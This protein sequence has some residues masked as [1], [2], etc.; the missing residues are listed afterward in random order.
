MLTTELRLPAAVE[1]PTAD[2]R[3]LRLEH[4]DNSFPAYTFQLSVHRPPDTGWGPLD[5]VEHRAW[6]ADSDGIVWTAASRFTAAWLVEQLALAAFEN[7]RAP[8]TRDEQPALHALFDHAPLLEGVRYFSDDRLY[9]SLVIGGR[10][11]Q[12]IFKYTTLS[13]DVA[14]QTDA[15]DGLRLHARLREGCLHCFPSPDARERVPLPALVFELD[16]PSSL[17]T[18]NTAVEGPSPGEWNDSPLVLPVRWERTADRA[19][20]Q[21]GVRVV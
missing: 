14:V 2:G 3:A 7:V 18:R 10:W 4:V 13:F 21:P 15:P 16:H 6:M 11:M 1:H 9:R 17:I 20:P 19:A 12:C 5:I 8:R